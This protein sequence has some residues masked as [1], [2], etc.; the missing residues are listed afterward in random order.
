MPNPL[1]EQ[2]WK[3]AAREL[4]VDVPAIKAIAE[5]ESPRGAFYPSG[6]PT[7]LFERHKFHKFT[8]GKWSKSHPALSNPKPGGYGLFSEQPDRLSQAAKL[9]RVAALKSTSFGKFQIM[10]FNHELAGF[11]VLQDFIN[12]MWAGERS[13]LKAFVNFIK[14]AGIA[15]ALRSHDWETVAYR[16]NGPMHAAND[17]V[18]KL[19]SAYQKYSETA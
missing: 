11:P 16:Y 1:T 10:G 9:D 2:D 8:N 19:K 3:E 6:E 14:N 4:G 15:Q 5:V 12:A 18:G 7:M 17:Y 13:Q